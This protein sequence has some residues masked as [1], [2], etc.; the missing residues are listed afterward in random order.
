MPL[1]ELR[2]GNFVMYPAR[3]SSAKYFVLSDKV[4]ER[5]HRPNTLPRS[6]WTPSPEVQDNYLVR[7]ETISNWSD[8][9]ARGMNAEPDVWMRGARI[10]G[11]A[12]N[13]IRAIGVQDGKDVPITN[14]ANDHEGTDWVFTEQFA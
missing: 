14:L 12:L 13:T 11:G 9:L 3:L 8:M 6:E 10:G 5:G 4:G 2:G 7:A 1:P